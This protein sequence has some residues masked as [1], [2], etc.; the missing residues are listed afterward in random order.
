MK[1]SAELG[2]TMRLRGTY[3]NIV[4]CGAWVMVPLVLV[5]ISKPAEETQRHSPAVD[6]M[7][8]V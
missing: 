8:S 1:K 6:L 5:N 2:M 4:T 3:R 7:P